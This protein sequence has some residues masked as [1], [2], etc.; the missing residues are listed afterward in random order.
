[1]TVRRTMTHAFRRQA[2]PRGPGT[3]SHAQTHSA[4]EFPRPGPP[5]PPRV[6]RRGGPPTDPRRFFPRVEGRGGRRWSPPAGSGLFYLAG[7]DGPRERRREWTPVLR[8]RQARSGDLAS[9]CDVPRRAA[10]GLPEHGAAARRPRA[11]VRR[12]LHPDPDAPLGPRPRD[13]LPGRDLR[14]GSTGAIHDAG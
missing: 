12:V 6:S 3:L 9:R 1:M 14:R 11:P 7:E 13:R 10:R 2:E 8:L 4:R 5:R